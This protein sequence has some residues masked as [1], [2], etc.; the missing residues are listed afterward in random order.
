[1]ADQSSTVELVSGTIELMG[2]PLE[3]DAR[4][5]WRAPHEAG[6][7]DFINAYLVRDGDGAVM[8]ETG[9]VAHFPVIAAQIERLYP[10]SR[11]PLRLVVTRNEPDCLSNVTNLARTRGLEKVYAPGIINSLDYFEHLTSK[12]LMMSYG[13]PHQALRPG[14][15]VEIGA[16]RSLEAVATPLKMLSTSWYHEADTGALFCSDV[17]TNGSSDRPDGRVVDA[18]EDMDDLVARMKEHFTMRYDW[19][20]GSDCR[21]IIRALEALFTRLQPRLLLPSRGA[22]IR[23]RAAVEQRIEALLRALREVSRA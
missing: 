16:G 8:V 11:G 15:R 7:Y 22:A 5:S 14:E 12:E 4:I 10:A 13:V 1:M 6:R 19:L 23:G 18:P 3:I 17:M 21:P 2:A 20:A 9:V